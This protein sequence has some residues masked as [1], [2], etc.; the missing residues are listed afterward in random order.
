[1]CSP[2]VVPI[3]IPNLS[4]YRLAKFGVKRRGKGEEKV[5]P[6][7]VQNPDFLQRLASSGGRGA[8]WHAQHSG[9]MQRRTHSPLGQGA[10]LD[11]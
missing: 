6:F 3:Q 2:G 1:M 11:P 10:C 5:I 9:A 8:C 4:G 7:P